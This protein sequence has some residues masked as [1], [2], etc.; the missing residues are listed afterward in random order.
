MLRCD[1]QHTITS[2]LEKVTTVK[3]IIM[4]Q[5]GKFAMKMGVVSLLSVMPLAAQVENGVNFTT[6]F[7][8]YAGD[9]KLPAGTYRVTSLSAVGRVL[10]LRNT[11]GTH[12]AMV[13]FIPTS[14]VDPNKDSDV[15]FDKIGDTGYLRALSLAGETDGI[16]FAQSKAERKAAAN[17]TELA[18][19]T[20]G[21]EHVTL[22]RGE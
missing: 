4:N 5:F 12:E 3:E 9:V 21:V 11:T 20:V 2:H 22:S 8:F 1:F 7:P 14:S 10:L 17:A 15:T 16:E 13:S 6:P 19:S 18:E